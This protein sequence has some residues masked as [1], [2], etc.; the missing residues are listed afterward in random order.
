MMPAQCHRR[1]A[2]NP[3]HAENI[4][5]YIL[6]R[7]ANQS[8]E[9]ASIAPRLVCIQ[10]LPCARISSALIHR[11][12]Q[13]PDPCPFEHDERQGYPTVLDSSLVATGHAG[14]LPATELAPGDATNQRLRHSDC[15]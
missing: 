5:S 15:P 8:F 6:G 4:S 3:L 9:I 12:S 2:F 1:C 7:Q 14:T 11:M 13:E 10:Q